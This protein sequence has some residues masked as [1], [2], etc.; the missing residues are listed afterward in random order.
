M[1]NIPPLFSFF[2][3][4]LISQGK[5]VFERETISTSGNKKGEPIMKKILPFLLGMTFTAASIGCS[6]GGSGD[7]DATVENQES[8]M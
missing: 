7:S 2:P 4:N 6:G 5:Q 8:V 3:S 1:K